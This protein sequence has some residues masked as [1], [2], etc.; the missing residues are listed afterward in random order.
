[1]RIGID[2][3]NTIANYDS[4]FAPVAI[5][6]GFVEH[7][8][9]GTKREVHRRVYK[10][11]SG[12]QEWMR[13]QGQLYG[14][15]MWRSE[16]ME[17]VHDFLR[18]CNSNAVPIYVISHKTEFGH[19]DED[20]IP[21]RKVAM[22]WMRSLHFFSGDGYKIPEEH[23]YF[24]STRS[25]KVQFIRE[26]SCTHF[27]DDLIEVFQEPHFP[28]NTKQYL[29]HSNSAITPPHGHTYSAWSQIQNDVFGK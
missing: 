26:T 13:L 12:E 18:A 4:V 1:M 24:A 11:G 5:D 22:D 16:L 6:L 19:F 21:L 25:E 9:H 29:L 27:I 14:K 8:F 3:D 15:H 20:K 23:V 28:E 7:G 17:G 2:F 10:D